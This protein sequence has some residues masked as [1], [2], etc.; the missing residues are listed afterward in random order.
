[1]SQLAFKT[2]PMTSEVWRIEEFKQ[3]T[4]DVFTLKLLPASEQAPRAFKGGQFNMIYVYGIGEV[5]ISLSGD[6]TRLSP[7]A[8]LVHTVRSVG[9]VTKIM[10]T[11]KEGDMVGIRGPFGNHWPIEDH[12]GNDIVIVAGGIGL[13]PLR[14]IIYYV[15]ANREK[16]G[17]L[18]ILYG[19]RTPKDV[20]FNDELQRWR[21]VERNEVYVSVDRAEGNWKGDVGVVT[22][23]MPRITIESAATAA[24]VCGPEIMMKY[25]VIGLQGIGV[26]E[27]NCYISME[28]NMKCGI[29][30]CGHCQLGPE[31][32]CKDGPVYRYQDIEYFL[33]IREA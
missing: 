27:T 29:G 16:Y 17:K 4:N 12:Y 28:R 32:I 5:P 10:S 20:L 19:A 14:P 30:F 8:P 31:F 7:P 2:D 11:L 9:P 22:Q 6:P 1:M 3:E 15:L 13:A 21:A 18:V 24:F 26:P 25:S 23:L 33:S